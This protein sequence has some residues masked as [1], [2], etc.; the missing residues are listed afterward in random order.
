MLVLGRKAG[1]KVWIR[2]DI[3]VTVLEVRGKTVKLGIDAP[4]GVTIR[5][6]ELIDRETPAQAA[7]PAR[8]A[9]QPISVHR[10]TPRRTPSFTTVSA[11]TTCLHP[12]HQASWRGAGRH[13]AHR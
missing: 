13:A 4:P 5:R 10:L 3:C 2:E 6:G 1:Q 7:P 12:N 8:P 11:G 9:K